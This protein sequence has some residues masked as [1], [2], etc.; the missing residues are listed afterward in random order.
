M[1]KQR[2]L[3]FVLMLFLASAAFANGEN[4]TTGHAEKGI[5]HE[6]EGILPFH[7][8]AEGHTF[9]GVMLIL[10][11]ASLFYAFYSLIQL[12]RKKKRKK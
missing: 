7:H 12:S 5:G 11:W 4:A 2:N 9:A 6:L 3:T 8:F 1:L 10:L